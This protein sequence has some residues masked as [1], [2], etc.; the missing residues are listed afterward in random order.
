MSLETRAVLFSLP[1]TTRT[2]MKIL[3]ITDVLNDH[4][5]FHHSIHGTVCSKGWE[6]RNGSRQLNLLGEAPR[7]LSSTRRAAA[8]AREWGTSLGR[9]GLLSSLASA[10]GRRLFFLM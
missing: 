9:L 5:R 8:A 6:C 2:A 10:Q 7:A 3:V 4:T 1:V